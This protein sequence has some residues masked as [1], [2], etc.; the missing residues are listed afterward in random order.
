[1]EYGNLL[2]DIYTRKRIE[3]VASLIKPGSTVLD[4]GCYTGDLLTQVDCDYTGIDSD[5]EALAIARGRGAETICL[6]ID[7]QELPFRYQK[8]D[9]VI[10]TEV[11]EH[12][13]NPQRLLEKVSGM[14]DRVIISIPNECTIMHRMRVLFGGGIN[15]ICFS[16]HYHLHFP[17]ITQSDRLVRKYFNIIE[18]HYWVHLGRLP[19][20][21]WFGKALA[22]LM[23]GLFARGVIY[24]GGKRG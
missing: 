17:S 6:D 15:G 3:Y 18:K 12:L 19:I 13:K 20:P 2:T 24:V 21:Y 5:P 8:F 23:P 7:S 14:T 22:N 11:L 16:P 1:V 10:I 9:V 4:L